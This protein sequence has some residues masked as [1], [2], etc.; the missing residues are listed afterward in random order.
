MTT[1]FDILLKVAQH[2]P[3]TRNG[4]AYGGTTS[5]LVDTYCLSDDDFWAAGTIF[6]LSGTN[7]GLSSF[8]TAYD[9]PTTT[10]TFGA[11]TNA[12]VAGVRYAAIDSRFTRDSLASALNQALSDLGPYD[13]YDE[14]LETVADQ[15]VYTLPA[16]NDP[17][18]VMADASALVHNLKR[19][20]IATQ[21]SA[22]YEW[23]TPYRYWHEADGALYLD[24]DYLPAGGYKMRLTYSVPFNQ[25]LLADTNPVP[26][27]V[28]PERLAWEGVWHALVNRSD[29]IRLSEPGMKDYYALVERKRAELA[30]RYPIQ[31][32]RKDPRY[33]AYPR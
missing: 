23:G 26:D 11:M 18:V 17:L 2:L 27:A 3:G 24:R 7:Q 31:R 21:T 9:K 33:A 20:E 15:D 13:L 19:V 12:I 16:I 28:H 4:R 6:F 30:A 29:V 8:I 1:V 14:S 25:Y 22:P 32:A 10:F 5:T